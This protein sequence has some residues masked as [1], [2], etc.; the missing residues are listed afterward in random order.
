MLW[1]YFDGY[2]HH[3][4]TLISKHQVAFDEQKQACVG[5]FTWPTFP[6]C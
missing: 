4:Q 3:L 2:E 6:P 5:N 1:G